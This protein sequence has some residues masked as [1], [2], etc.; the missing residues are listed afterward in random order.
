MVLQTIDVMSMVKLLK[1]SK[2]LMGKDVE[3]MYLI[4]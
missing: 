3:V 2:L 4:D 1:K